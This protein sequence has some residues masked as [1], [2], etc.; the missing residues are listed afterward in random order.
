MNQADDELTEGFGRFSIFTNLAGY[1]WK[2][3]AESL[4][5][6]HPFA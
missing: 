4:A 3:L 6:I 2:K 5:G 1:L